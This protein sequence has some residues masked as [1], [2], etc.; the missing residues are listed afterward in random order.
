MFG[1]SAGVCAHQLLVLHTPR[2]ALVVQ[3]PQIIEKLVEVPTFI[4]KIVEVDDL[5]A[6][7]KLTVT[8]VK[9]SNLMDEDWMP[10]E[11]DPYM[12]VKLSDKACDSCR[13]ATVESSN[14]PQ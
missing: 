8:V 7:G 9:A 11:L 13:T 3:Q 4:E 1:A 6:S 12:I 14:N 2:V 5:S 10:G